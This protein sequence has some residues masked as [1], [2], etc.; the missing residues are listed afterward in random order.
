MVRLQQPSRRTAPITQF[1]LVEFK[2]K[3]APYNPTFL[4]SGRA[5]CVC[6]DH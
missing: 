1:H 2:L 3:R 6:C 5:S 4:S